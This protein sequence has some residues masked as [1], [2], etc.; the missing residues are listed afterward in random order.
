M[1]DGAGLGVPEIKRCVGLRCGCERF[2]RFFFWFHNDLMMMIAVTMVLI[3][4]VTPV[5]IAS[6]D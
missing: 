1:S 5:T 4:A 2:S 3:A 6:I